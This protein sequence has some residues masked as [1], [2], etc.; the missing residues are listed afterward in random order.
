MEIVLVLPMDQ[1]HPQYLTPQ[2]SLCKWNVLQLGSGIEAGAVVE[3]RHLC[4]VGI[5]LLFMMYKMTHADT[6]GLL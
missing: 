3:A 1:T 5:E 6:L 2:L 4:N